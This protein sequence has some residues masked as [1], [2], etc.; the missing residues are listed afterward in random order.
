MGILTLKVSPVQ[1]RP[2]EFLAALF[3]AVSA[4]VLVA[5]ASTPVSEV[6]AFAASFGAV[7]AAVLV[8]V[9]STAVSEVAAFA[10][11]FHS[12]RFNC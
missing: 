5:V 4:A 1:L 11:A 10:I 3:G 9:A 6:A 12:F 2:E 8:A 7:S